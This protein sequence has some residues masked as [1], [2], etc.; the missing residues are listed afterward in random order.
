MLD[1]RLLRAFVAIVDA[2]SFTI[3]ADKLNMTQSTI[4][5]QLARLEDAVGKQL[6]DRIV[7]PVVPTPAGERLIGYARRILA[8]QH[9]AETILADPA[10]TIS[11]RIGLPEDIVSPGMAEIFSAFSAAN[12]T[13]RLDVVAGLSRDLT[14]RYRAGEL[15]IVVVKEPEPSSDCRATFPE[16]MAW[17]QRVDHSGDW[18]DP[19][20]LIVFPPGGLY[21]DAMFERI[22]LAKRRWYVAFSGSSLHNVL[23]AVEAGLGLSM[24]PIGTTVGRRVRTFTGMGEEPAIAVSLYAWGDSSMVSELVDEMTSYLSSRHSNLG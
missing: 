12:R 6:V 17:Y 1:P 13:I 18:P 5:Q 22:E 21:R 19:V 24:L 4:S 9:E 7:R 23:T 2:G 10:G 20:P 8:L 16:A 15:D 14:E 11:I 3:A